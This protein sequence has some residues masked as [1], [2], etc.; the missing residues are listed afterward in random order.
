[1]SMLFDIFPDF[2]FGPDVRQQ[3]HNDSLQLSY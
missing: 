2:D 1:M 3:E